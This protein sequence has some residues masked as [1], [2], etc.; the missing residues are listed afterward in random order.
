[1]ADPQIRAAMAD[2]L[3]A[4]PACSRHVRAAE[5]R[6][7]FCAV[8][9]PEASLGRVALGVAIS[10]GLVFTCCSVY[11]SPGPPSPVVDAGGEATTKF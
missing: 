8:R 2:R 5:R 9:F 3:L 11:G 7:P 6:C 10:T 4:C 1:M